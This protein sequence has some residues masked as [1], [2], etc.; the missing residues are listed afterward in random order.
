M[1]RDDRAGGALVGGPYWVAAGLLA[2]A[3]AHWQEIDGIGLSEGVDYAAIFHRSPS[4][5]LSAL[6]VLSVRGM[7]E[8]EREQYDF[9][10]SVPPAWEN[11]AEPSAEELEADGSAF[12]AAAASFPGRQG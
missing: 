8:T 6:Y 10:L 7:D 2:W 3:E 12:L 11:V 1:R 5:F 9:K 4:R